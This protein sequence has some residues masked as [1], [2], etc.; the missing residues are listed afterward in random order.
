MAEGSNISSRLTEPEKKA[1]KTVSDFIAKQSTTALSR[2]C[3][4]DIDIH[5]SDVRK[6]SFGDV[7]FSLTDWNSLA[8]GVHVPFHG[9]LEGNLLLLFPEAGVQELEKSLS[10][11]GNLSGRTRK[12][13]VFSEIINTFTG[14]IL[15]VLS[16]ITEKVLVP[17]STLLVYDMAGAILDALLAD[18]GARSDDATVIVFCIA[19]LDGDALVKCV[20]IP[21]AAGIELLLEA[22]CRLG[23]VR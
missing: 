5:V 15:S 9:D 18:V 6:M 17:S 13:S 3:D 2:N 11:S 22:A 19:D 20:F 14:A 16:S 1:I 12:D 8:L 21:G 4:I 7:P 23:D 10:G